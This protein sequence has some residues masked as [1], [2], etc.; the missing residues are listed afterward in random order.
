MQRGEVWWVSFSPLPGGE[1]RKKRP[2]VIVSKH[3]AH[4]HLNYAQVVPLTS[5]KVDRVYPSGAAVMPDGRKSQAMADQ[6]TAVA[7]LRLIHQA[8]GLAQSERQ[9]GA[10]GQGTVGV[11]QGSAMRASGESAESLPNTRNRGSCCRIAAH[12]AG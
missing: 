7:R 8:G 3:A 6:L 10:C 9:H 11:G 12:F 2:V 4:K 1:I 5:S